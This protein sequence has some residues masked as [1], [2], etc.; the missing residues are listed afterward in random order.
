[1]DSLIHGA[2][3]FLAMSVALQRHQDNG[4]SKS[5]DRISCAESDAS[6]PPPQL[7]G[8]GQ[9]PPP[10]FY[11]PAGTR[12]RIMQADTSQILYNKEQHSFAVISD[13]DLASRDAKKFRWKSIYR[14]GLLNLKSDSGDVPNIEWTDTYVVCKIAHKQM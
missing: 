12:N 8:S 1:M 10:S 3:V 7:P 5:N 11:S 9:P 2:V 6:A 14:E 4:H 13:L